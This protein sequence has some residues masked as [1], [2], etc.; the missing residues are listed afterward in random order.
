MENSVGT[1]R[2]DRLMQGDHPSQVTVNTGSTV[3]I[4]STSFTR[5]SHT[6]KQPLL[7]FSDYFD[8]YE[9][10]Q[11]T[12][13]LHH[14]F[15]FFP[16][17]RLLTYYNIEITILQLPSVNDYYTTPKTLYSY[18]FDICFPPIPLPCC[19]LNPHLHLLYCFSYHYSN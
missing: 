10:S 11:T 19:P 14:L 7:P 4:N 16:F 6:K 18:S 3:L 1:F 2:T 13:N 12:C 8:C 17:P 5:Q 15:Y 9:T